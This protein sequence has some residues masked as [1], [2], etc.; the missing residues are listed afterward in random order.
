MLS[1]H[2]ASILSGGASISEKSEGPSTVIP[3]LG[4]EIDS[5]AMELRLPGDKL[6]QLQH[7]LSQWRGKKACR[8][9]Y[10]RLLVAYHMCAKWSNQA[11]HSFGV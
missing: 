7:T 2:Y 8:K 9:S 6:A 3:F 4:I 10:Y 5:L 1:A 11:E